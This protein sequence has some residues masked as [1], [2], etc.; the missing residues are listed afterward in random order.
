MLKTNVK[1]YN[2]I[3]HTKTVHKIAG[4]F[5]EFSL[6]SVRYG[7]TRYNI[8]H[9]NKRQSTH[10]RTLSILF[11]RLID[12]QCTTKLTRNVNITNESTRDRWI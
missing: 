5:R 4:R 7:T 9:G 3:G 8:A 1:L 2:T 11:P 12:E 6:I 10:A